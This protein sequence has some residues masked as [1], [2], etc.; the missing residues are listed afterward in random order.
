MLNLQHFRGQ[1]HQRSTISFCMRRSWKCKKDWQLDCLFALLGSAKLLV[2][3]WWIWP[4]LSLTT[5]FFNHAYYNKYMSIVLPL[6]LLTFTASVTFKRSS[7]ASLTSKAKVFA[8]C[9]FHQRFMRACMKVFCKAFLYLQ[10]VIVIY[11]PKE[12]SKKVAHKM[13]VELTPGWT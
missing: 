3:R 13:L 7:A 10:F 11:R 6:L 12:I 5:Y 4:L 8:W 1:F 9:Q 2:E